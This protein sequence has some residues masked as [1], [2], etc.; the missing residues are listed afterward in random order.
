[1]HV[2]SSDHM[3]KFDEQEEEDPIFNPL[4]RCPNVTEAE[5]NAAQ[6]EY[7]LKALMIAE[8]ETFHTKQAKQDAGIRWADTLIQSALTY[9]KSEYDRRG[10][11]M[12]EWTRM[13]CA[14]YEPED[15]IDEQ[16]GHGISEFP[17]DA[18]EMAE[19]TET[20]LPTFQVFM[21]IYNQQQLQ[22]MP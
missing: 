2:C 6:I 5:T 14:D 16:A 12:N 7:W 9:S 21:E 11:D 13:P 1:M 15:F 17:E 8:L 18:S 4:V 22:K 10:P 19:T 20:Y 3:S